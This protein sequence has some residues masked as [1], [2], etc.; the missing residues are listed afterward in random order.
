MSVTHESKRQALKA[1]FARKDL[2]TAPGIFDMISAKMA[3]SMGFECL[4]MTG[5]GTVASYLGLPDAGLATYTDMVNRVAAFCGGTNTPMICDG[6]TGYGGLL[7]VAHTVRGYE[8]AGA[9][10]IQL[11]DQ[12]FPKKCGHTPG[13]RVIPL[14]DMVRKIKVAAESRSD[15]NFQIIAR[16]DAR[17]SLG[18]DEA[19]RRAEAF[20]KA[21]A[22]VLFIESPES[23]EEL[24][25]IGRSFDQPLLVNVVEGGRTPQLAPDEFQ[26]LGFTLAI[27]PATG[28]L[29]A[30]KALKDAYGQILARKNTESAADAM[31]PFSAMC[32]LMGFPDVWAFDRAH[33][34]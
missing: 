4:Y 24:E 2:V 20:A 29:T 22:D 31:Y 26:K 1:R 30:A 10:G 25:K 5:F 19:L 27:Y 6:D 32:E 33:A 28:F 3:D 17:T 16:T 8:Q 12:E 34:D 7:N 9:A 23:V 18:L 15:S 13:R 21:G 11:E 14:E